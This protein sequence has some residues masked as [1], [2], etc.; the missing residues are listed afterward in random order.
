MKKRTLLLLA[1]TF[2]IYLEWGTNNYAFGFTIEWLIIKQIVQNP[3]QL[4]HPILF[5]LLMSQIIFLIDLFVRKT[6]KILY[7]SAFV[8]LSL[9]VIFVFV[10]GIL[11]L[12]WKIILSTLPYLTV[13]FIVLNDFRTSKP[14][15]NDKT[16]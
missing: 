9:L 10:I 3:N 7:Y 12:N 4:L 16:L 2:L 5:P 8:F 13:S 1:C 15:Q 11:K 14:F 6:H